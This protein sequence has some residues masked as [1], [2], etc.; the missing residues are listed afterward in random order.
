MLQE[1]IIHDLSTKQKFGM[2][3]WIKASL[4]KKNENQFKEL[5]TKPVKNKVVNGALADLALY[6]IAGAAAGYK[7]GAI[8][9]DSTAVANDDTALGSQILTRKGATGT[10]ITTSV[11]NDT[12]QF[13][14]SFTADAA[15]SVVEYGTFE[16]ATGGEILS[17]V[18]FGAIALTSGDALA[19][20]HKVQAQRA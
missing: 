19:F 8:G 2:K 9:T 10:R 18:V 13:V 20:T 17:R 6:L 11:A 4:K 15:Y 16:T 5:W 1:L 12:A 7:Y 3:G 14:S